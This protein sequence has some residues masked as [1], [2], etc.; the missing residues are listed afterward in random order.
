[1]GQ[2]VF[3]CSVEETSH[4]E[5]ICRTFLHPGQCHG[6]SHLHRWCCGS[7]WCC[8]NPRCCSQ[9][10]WS[11]SDPVPW[12]SSSCHPPPEGW[13]CGAPPCQLCGSSCS[14]SLH[15]H[16]SGTWSHHHPP[17]GSRGHQASALW[18]HCPE[19]ICCLQ[20]PHRQ[21]AD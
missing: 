10:C 3:T 17:T 14:C 20:R 13:T 9:H 15:H 11:S 8:C 21:G 4:H 7:R 19:G 18:P 2:S 12:A 1:M 6:S 16:C 5:A